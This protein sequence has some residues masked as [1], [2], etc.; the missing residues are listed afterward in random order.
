VDNEPPLERALPDKAGYYPY[1]LDPLLS[2]SAGKHFLTI[3]VPKAGA[4]LD[5][6]EL[7]PRS[8]APATLASTR[9]PD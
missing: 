4:K 5:L 1:V 9:K 6:L 2:L 8:R 3:V 7:V